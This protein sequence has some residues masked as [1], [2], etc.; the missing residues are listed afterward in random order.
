MTTYGQP[1]PTVGSVDFYIP[2]VNRTRA[3]LQFISSVFLNNRIGHVEHV[4]F[5]EINANHPVTIDADGKPLPFVKHPTIVSAYVKVSFWDK[6]TL[7]AYDVYYRMNLRKLYLFTNS[8]EHW[9]ILY[10]NTPID[11]SVLNIHQVAHYTTEVQTKVADLS[12]AMEAIIAQ[13]KELHKLVES[14]VNQNATMKT[15]IDELKTIKTIKTQSKTV[16]TIVTD[17]HNETARK[18]TS[19]CLCGNS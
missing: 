2:R 18:L 1:F 14:L 9:L 19:Q 4:D 6:A 10:N 8:D 17:P 16:I 7:E 11:R 3:S 5:V 13:N 12:T 15:E